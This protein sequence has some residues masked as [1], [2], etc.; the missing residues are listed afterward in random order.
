MK[1]GKKQHGSP[2]LV[3]L[4]LTWCTFTRPSLPEKQ[5]EPE[6][7]QSGGGR[8]RAQ[9]EEEEE[10]KKL[11]LK[12]LQTN[13]APRAPRPNTRATEAGRLLTRL[14]P[15]K[16][17]SHRLRKPRKT[18]SE[19]AALLYVLLFPTPPIGFRIQFGFPFSFFFVPHMGWAG[20]GQGE[21]SYPKRERERVSCAGGGLRALACAFPPTKLPYSLPFAAQGT[22]SNA[23]TSFNSELTAAAAS[24]PKSRPASQPACLHSTPPTSPLP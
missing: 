13:L 24:S 3:A 23:H 8:H 7:G 2:A 5:E 21:L 15:T 1:C 4:C 9:R 12:K 6:H 10:E 14:D 17:T 16:F 22:H 18:I 20:A 11:K 19:N